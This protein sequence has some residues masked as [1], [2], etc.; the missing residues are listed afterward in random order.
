MD[1]LV[2]KPVGWDGSGSTAV[3]YLTMSDVVIQLIRVQNFGP[4]WVRTTTSDGIL[5]LVLSE[6][7]GSDSK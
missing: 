5:I 2:Q 7:L 3:M 4:C 6:R 1:L